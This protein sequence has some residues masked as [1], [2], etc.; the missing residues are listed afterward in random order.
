MRRSEIR[1]PRNIRRSRQ[2]GERDPMIQLRGLR[3]VVMWCVAALAVGVG[4]Y[5][6]GVFAQSGPDMTLTGILLGPTP[7][8]II[9][10][11]GVTFITKVGEPVGDAVVAAI[12]PA[13]VVLRQ[14]RTTL[15]LPAPSARRAALGAATSSRGAAPAVPPEGVASVPT[16]STRS[17]PVSPPRGTPVAPPSPGGALPAQPGTG[18]TVTGILEGK[19]RV[20]IVQAGGQSYVA[21]AG[22]PVGDAVVVSILPH[23]VV[24]KKNGVLFE[25][26]IGGSVGR[27]TSS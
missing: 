6:D 25:L 18:M 20:A 24:L 12:L 15:E 5:A 23:K 9:R 26:P 13:K 19:N 1:P 3:P 4:P 17:T 27:K 21:G 10:A 11:G 22:D 8:A 2:R 16:G 14:G 7:V